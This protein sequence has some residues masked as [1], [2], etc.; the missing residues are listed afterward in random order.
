LSDKFYYFYE[1][2]PRTDEVFTSIEA[3]ITVFRKQ[4]DPR[5]V[6]LFTNL[7]KFFEAV[8][9][10][11]HGSA[12]TERI[13]SQLAMIKTRYRNS[14]NIETVENVL[15]CKQLLKKDTCYTWQPTKD[16]INFKK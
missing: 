9:S 8:I 10:F 13:F 3:F 12:A 6:L 2:G 14:L 16:L 7:I 15:F 11:P 1:T 4:K 5:G